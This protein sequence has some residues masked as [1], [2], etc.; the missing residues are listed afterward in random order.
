[1]ADSANAILLPEILLEI[2]MLTRPPLI[3]SPNTAPVPIIGNRRKHPRLLGC[4]WSLSQV[5]RLWRTLALGYPL[6]WSSFILSSA[7]RLPHLRLIRLQLTRS[8]NV[9]LEVM[10]WFDA[11]TQDA[12]NLD[13]FRA[14]LRQIAR[15]S[16][17]RWRRLKIVLDARSV[18]ANQFISALT[19]MPLLE[20]LV[21]GGALAYR[22]TDSENTIC[23]AP[24]LKRVVL[25]DPEGTSGHI[26]LPIDQII[27]Y[28][29][30][31]RDSYTNLRRMTASLL[32]A[33]LVHLNLNHPHL[34]DIEALELPR[35][36]RLAVEQSL[37][38]HPLTAPSLGELY[39]QLS[40]DFQNLFDFLD[41]SHCVL[42]SLTL[43]YCDS[44]APVIGD[45]LRHIPT[46]NNFAIH[47]K[48]QENGVAQTAL[49]IS[50]LVADSD[51]DSKILCPQL[52]SLSFGD[53]EDTLASSL[54][55][56]A[57]VEMIKSRSAGS[58]CVRQGRCGRIRNVNV[59]GKRVR[60]GSAAYHIRALGVQVEALTGAAGSAAMVD[61]RKY[62]LFI[63]P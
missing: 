45:L 56:K 4:P 25:G 14:F 50:M 63:G 60:M 40:L 12:Q 38:L 48:P 32:E 19:H 23:K 31:H 17:S 6:L 29:S 27:S 36:R 15:E 2:F 54:Q 13:A 8:I 53:P 55:R 34:K 43:A 61:W 49:L 30:S 26:S 44:A 57:F 33:D 21:L 11:W 42:T 58:V 7:A 35:L 18:E 9:P 28:K 46:L 52:T 10:I 22:I 5:C 37:C 51:T 16:C 3:A 47:Y 41:R 62:D 20:E 59:Y 39:L 1:M 24:R